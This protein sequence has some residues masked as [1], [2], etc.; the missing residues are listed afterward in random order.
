ML[1]RPFATIS[2]LS[3]MLMV[4]GVVAGQTIVDNPAH[5]AGGVETISL[6]EQWRLGGEDEDFFFGTVSRIHQDQAGKIYILDGQLCQVHV[7]SGVGEILASLGNEGDGPGEMRGPGDFYVSAD[8]TVNIL[9]SFPGKI[10]KIAA[11]GN[12]AG[13]THFTVGGAKTQFGVLIRGLETD[14]GLYLGGIQMEFGGAG[15]SKQNYFLSYCDK[16]GGQIDRL[17]KKLHVIDYGDFRMEEKDMDFI[18]GRMAVGPHGQLYLA[19]SRNQYSISVMDP[20]G[21]VTRIINRSYKAPPRTERQKEIARQIIDAIAGY[22]PVPLK[23]KAIEKTEPAIG[24]LTVMNDG[25]LWVHANFSDEALPP[26]T[27]NIFDVFSPEGK[28]ERQVALKG[29]FNRNRDAAYLLPDGRLIVVTGALDAFLN[30]MGAGGQGEA[31]NETALLE[32]ICFELDN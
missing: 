1:S 7:L 23:S 2:C 31:A 10:V 28:L 11:D 4:A 18:W 26:G 3:F 32:V 13:T 21:T 14:K 22:H 30:Q 25:R 8:G 12:P 9:Q 27:W 19:E 24:G 16:D 20:D 17:A 6:T 29:S 15:P 5:P